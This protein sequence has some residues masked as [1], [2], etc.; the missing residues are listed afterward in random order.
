MTDLGFIISLSRSE[1]NWFLQSTFKST[2]N[3]YDSVAS[4]S[5]DRFVFGQLFSQ[6]DSLLK[7]LCDLDASFRTQKLRFR[8][9]CD[10]CTRPFCEGTLVKGVACVAPNVGLIHISKNCRDSLP[11]SVLIAA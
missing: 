10:V 4:D 9:L 5:F 7:V 11:L 8:A 1:S 6:L 3:Y 2:S